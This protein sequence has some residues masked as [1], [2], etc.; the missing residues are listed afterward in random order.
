MDSARV[1]DDRVRLRVLSK[2]GTLAG[3]LDPA[4]VLSQIAH[5]C[6]PELADWSLVDQVAGGKV[7]RVDVVY[8]HPDMAGAADELRRLPALWPR[9]PE[10]KER[11]LDGHSVVLKQIA[12]DLSAP[13]VRDFPFPPGQFELLRKIA[14]RSELFV[15]LV[16]G[17]RARSR[18]A[19]SCSFRWWSAI[20]RWRCW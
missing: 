17:D 13:G 19:P 10:L 7:Q 5:L 9:V 12:D 3:S 14:P 16:V 18:P 11:I 4:R 2:I 1:S 20:A 8:R 15:P 6:V